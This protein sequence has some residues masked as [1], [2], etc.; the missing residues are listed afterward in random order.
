MTMRPIKRRTKKDPTT[1]TIPT[2]LYE[3][4]ELGN[5]GG[6]RLQLR[7]SAMVR[8]GR[9]RWLGSELSAPSDAEASE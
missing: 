8:L 4:D 2:K 5:E 7:R 9:Y 3:T 6:R 1:G